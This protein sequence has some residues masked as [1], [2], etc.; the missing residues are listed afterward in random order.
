MKF[1]RIIAVL[2][3]AFMLFAFAACTGNDQP[4]NNVNTEIQDTEAEIPQEPEEPIEKISIVTTIFPQYDWA[5]EIIGEN[6]EYFDLTILVDSTIDMHSYNPS[7]SDI[8]KVKTADLFI[9]VGGH[10]DE[11]VEDVLEETVNRDMVT[12]NLVEELGDAILMV[13]HDCDDEECEDDHSEF[14]HDGEELH[15]E[16]HVWVSLKMAQTLCRVIADVIVE[17]HP[18]GMDVYQTNR[19]NYIAKLQNLDAQYT[20]MVAG[21]SGDTLVFA[22]R[23]PFQK[24]VSKL[25]SSFRE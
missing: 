15:E 18:E 11:W 5:R 2:L 8:A 13:E 20:S 1:K 6:S 10:S 22:D 7:A 3:A 19:D 16:E 12:I 21:A 17:L 4:G 25:S 9:Y 14:G 24:Q 23:F